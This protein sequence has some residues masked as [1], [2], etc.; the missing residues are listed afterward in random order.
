MGLHNV[1]NLGFEPGFILNKFA[2]IK[3]INIYLYIYYDKYPKIA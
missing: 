1:G 2:H 3:H